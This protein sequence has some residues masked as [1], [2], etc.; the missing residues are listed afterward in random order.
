MK[1]IRFSLILI[2]AYL[3][4]SVNSVFGQTAVD[5]FHADVNTFVYRVKTSSDK[6]Y[7]AGPTFTTVNGTSKSYLA[8]LLHNGAL[9][10][11]YNP[12]PNGGVQG[13][14]FSGS[15]LVIVGGFTSIG[16]GASGGIARLNFDGTNDGTFTASINGAGVVAEQPDGKI[17]VGGS[18][19]TVSGVART[20]LARFNTDGSLDSTFAPSID[21]AVFGITI[22]PDGKILVAGQFTIVNGQA[23]WRFVR[24]NSDGSLDDSFNVNPAFPGAGGTTYAS[25]VQADGRSSSAEIS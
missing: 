24:L 8:R 15:K 9:D 21:S 18:F 12:N 23:R 14:G 5:G 11:L 25:A 19:T 6:I 13:I 4:I 16:G 1:N 17:L 20:Q 3:L 2:S 7:I 22:Q 10:T